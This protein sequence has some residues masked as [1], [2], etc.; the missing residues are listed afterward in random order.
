MVRWIGKLTSLLLLVYVLSALALYLMQDGL[1]YFPTGDAAQTWPE[2]QWI[3]NDG[4]RIQLWV[5]K[6]KGSDK[7][8]IYFGG[9]NED[10]TRNAKDFARELPDFTVY[11]VVYRGYG[12]ST[13]SPSEAALKSDALAV[14]AYV[15]E[16]HIH[17]LAM[18]RSLGSGV[19]SYLAAHRNMTGLVLVTPYD[20][21]LAV[22]RDLYPYY[23][24]EWLMR[25][26]Y[27]SDLIAPA[28]SLPTLLLVAEGDRIVPPAHAYRLAGLLPEGALKQVSTIPGAR[29][30]GISHHTVYWQLLRAFLAEL[31]SSYQAG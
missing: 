14:H 2:Q 19:A 9:N 16:R 23:P 28:L 26:T 6:G 17:V 20:S 21:L 18:G 10:V 25:D 8:I 24:L 15:R 13:G 1:L 12:E 4:E 31:D 3:E 11:L 7:A 27:R 30:N 22:A 29:H 5:I